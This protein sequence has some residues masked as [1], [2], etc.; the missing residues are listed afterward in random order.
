MEDTGY[1]FK[2]D[3]FLGGEHWLSLRHQWSY[4]KQFMDVVML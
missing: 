2:P 1:G 3:S 4:A